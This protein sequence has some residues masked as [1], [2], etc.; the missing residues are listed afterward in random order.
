[1]QR[2]NLKGGLFADVPNDFADQ[3]AEMKWGKN[4]GNQTASPSTPVFFDGVGKFPLSDVRNIVNVAVESY[5]NTHVEIMEKCT[6]RRNQV[7]KW[8]PLKKAERILK[9][10]AY[11]AFRS[12]GNKIFQ[13]DML[14]DPIYSKLIS[15]ILEF[16]E[17]NPKSYYCPGDVYEHLISGRPMDKSI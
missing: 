5:E 4:G 8:D 12:R 3:V 7:K 11:I 2:I 1:M 9:T 17:N 10:Y 15:P 14:Q 13:A 16:F 6:A